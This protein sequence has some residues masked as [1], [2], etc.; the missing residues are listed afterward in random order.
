MQRFSA[1]QTIC[2]VFHVFVS[3]HTQHT[4]QQHTAQPPHNLAIT[5]LSRHTTRMRQIQWLYVATVPIRLI[6]NPNTKIT[7]FHCTNFSPFGFQSVRPK[8]KYGIISSRYRLPN[9]QPPSVLWQQIINKCATARRG[10]IINSV[11]FPSL[12]FTSAYIQT[13]IMVIKIGA[14]SQNAIPSDEK[15][16]SAP[17]FPP[18]AGRRR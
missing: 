10:S 13:P 9:C 6:A 5:Q 14:I 16:E 3:I 4:T 1:F 15:N 2:V 18:A 17:P 8:N 12:F 7:V 11:R